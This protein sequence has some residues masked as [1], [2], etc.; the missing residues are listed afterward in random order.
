M[1]SDIPETIVYSMRLVS[2]YA[3]S[4]GLMIWVG[5]RIRALYLK[6]GLDLSL[7]KR[8]EGWFLP[9]PATFLIGADGV[10]QARFAD[11]DFRKR[12]RPCE[13]SFSDC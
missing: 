6:A 10:V 12:M 3:L 11:P 5:D 7:F 9:I 8:N 2:D 4:I 13:K 1:V